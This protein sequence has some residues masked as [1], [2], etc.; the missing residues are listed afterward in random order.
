VGQSD[1]TIKFNLTRQLVVRSYPRIRLSNIDCSMYR[2]AH[3][4]YQPI[5]CMLSGYFLYAIRL[6]PLQFTIAIPS[7]I[8]AFL[9][10]SNTCGA[11]EIYRNELY[12]NGVANSGKT[13]QV[14]RQ[15]FSPNTC[16]RSQR[17]KTIQ[18]YT[19]LSS[20]NQSVLSTIKRDR[21]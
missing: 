2:R 20:E 19:R 18:R 8:S 5:L 4:S 14:I 3:V 9:G 13:D 10:H 21:A 11:R 16:N 15:E 1:K 17:N 7:I 6:F 12:A